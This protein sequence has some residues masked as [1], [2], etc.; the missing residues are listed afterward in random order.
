MRQYVVSAAY[1]DNY[2]VVAVDDGRV[3]SDSI[4]AYY[5]LD[6][7]T[8]ALEQLGYQKSYFLPAAQQKLTEAEE[9]YK[10]AKEEYEDAKENALVI[11]E[12]EAQQV[13]IFKKY[14][15]RPGYLI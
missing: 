14:F 12:R 15:C 11:D 8:R 10:N 1:T 2:H 4:V 6:G 7:Y 5:E 9:L 13:S 3:V